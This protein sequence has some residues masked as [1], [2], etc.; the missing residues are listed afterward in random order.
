MKASRI[1]IWGDSRCR[2]QPA[3]AGILLKELAGACLKVTREWLGVREGTHA[4]HWAGGKSPGSSHG[5]ACRIEKLETEIVYRQL[6]LEEVVHRTKNTLELAVAKLDE[7][8]DAAR[9]AWI[10]QGL[11]NVQR[12]LRTFSRTNHRFYAPSKPDSPC[13]N[14]RLSEIC[15]SIFESMATFTSSM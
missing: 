1:N 12:Q 8:I 3:A 5:V 4:P 7:Y 2:D 9:D 10:R 14:F 15:S 11:R 13:L 6:L